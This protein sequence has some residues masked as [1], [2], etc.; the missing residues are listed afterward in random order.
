MPRP[1]GLIQRF[2]SWNHGLFYNS[3]YE[4][5]EGFGAIQV[6]PHLAIGIL[7]NILS[8]LTYLMIMAVPAIYYATNHCPGFS[9][10]FKEP[11]NKPP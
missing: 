9:E 3:I 8:N 6:I 5:F 11:L 1:C 4:D 2:L 7:L 10:I